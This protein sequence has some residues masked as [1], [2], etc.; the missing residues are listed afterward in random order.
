M[1]VNPPEARNMDQDS[2]RELPAGI[3]SA[4]GRRPRP[5][6]GPRPELSLERIVG[7]AVQ[8]ASA[9]GLDSVSMARVAGDIGASTMALYRYVAS[10]DELLELMVDAVYG[11]PPDGPGQGETWRDGLARWGWGEHDLLTRHAWV[12]R[13]PVRGAPT[14]P[15]SLA[16]FER[17]LECL[18]DSGLDWT[19]KS[20]VVL[21]VSSFVRGDV[22]VFTGV[23]RA[24]EEAGLSTLEAMAG[25][26]DMIMELAGPEDFPN[27][28]ALMDAAAFGRPGSEGAEFDAE[29]DADF[30]F[31]LA[32]LLDGVAVLVDQR[33]SR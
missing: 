21:L 29:F 20:S 11:A 5:R 19:E 16:W 28:R 22:S 14:L 15:N 12:L 26:R 25:Y 1:D 13:I 9:D 18:R 32:R 7:A 10:K 33:R 6:K 4:W 31:G 8:A 23:Q 2:E 30:D 24:F 27:V 17:G 3:A